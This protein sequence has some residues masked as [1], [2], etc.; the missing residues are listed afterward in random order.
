MSPPP[1][2]RYRAVSRRTM[3]KTALGAGAASV[4]GACA[5]ADAEVFGGQ[6]ATPEPTTTTAPTTTSTTTE[7]TISGPGIAVDGE[8]V[9]SFTYTRALGGKLESPYVAVWIEDDDGFL[10][11][12]V[13]LFY[14]QERRGARWLDHLDRWFTV[15]AQRIAAG[16]VDTAATISAAT[17]APG[18]YSVAW[19]GVASEEVVPAGPYFVCI[20]SVREDGPYSLIRERFNLTGS[21]PETRLPDVGELS[22]ASVRIN[23]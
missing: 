8:M 1:R 15:D 12:T 10:V 7:P 21:L 16:G 2:S 19:D 23:G 11:D 5:D 20:E 3:L 4:L 13:A 14:Q 18:A 9:I 17:R 22:L 6:V